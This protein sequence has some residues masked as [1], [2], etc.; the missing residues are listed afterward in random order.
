MNA[1]PARLTEGPIAGHLIRLAIPMVWGLLAIHI[2]N[3]TDTFFVGQLG[4]EPL[5]AMGFVYPLVMGFMSL[6]MGMGSGATAIVSRAIGEQD[7]ERIRQLTIDCLV[8]TLLVALLGIGIIFL[9]LPY[10]LALL[11]AD[12]LMQM[13]VNE[14]FHWWLIGAPLLLLA[15]VCNSLLRATGSTLWPSLV[16]IGAAILN[17]LL[18]P[19]FIFGML[20]FPRLELPG[21]AIATVCANGFAAL[22]ALLFLGKKEGM[23]HVRWSGWV[24]VIQCWKRMLH[25]GIPSSLTHMAVPL[26]VAWIVAILAPFGESAVAAYGVAVRMESFALLAVAALSSGLMPMIGQNMG[27]AQNERVHG[28]I[29][30]AFLLG[31][32]WAMG[33]ALLFGLFGEAIGQ[34]FSDDTEVIAIAN[35][36][37]LLVPFSYVGLVIVMLA[38]SA[39]NAT[40][41]PGKALAMNL[42]RTIGLYIPLAYL[43]RAWIGID[44]VFYA[45]AGANLLTGAYVW[46]WARRHW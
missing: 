19:L 35:R 26:S 44:G 34:V 2:M 13:K 15:M 27:A 46:G 5:A 28:A 3:L 25:I 33:I 24:L 42:T 39:C 21:A 4:T 10:L 40:D 1:I 29:Q 30:R 8:L 31:V 23:L 9:T 45:A 17:I 43:G 36:Y 37:L 41:R 14:Y 6:G 11:G 12:A 18:D 22:L 38:S 7:Y 16:M 32:L 20:G